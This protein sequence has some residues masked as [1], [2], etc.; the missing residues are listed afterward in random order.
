MTRPFVA[1]DRVRVVVPEDESEIVR[2]KGLPLE[3]DATVTEGMYEIPGHSPVTLPK[4][5][6]C[7]DHGWVMTS[8]LTHL[9]GPAIAAP[10]AP[11][12]ACRWCHGTG[13]VQLVF[14]SAPCECVSNSV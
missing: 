6:G 13:A 3:W 12:R 5:P 10:R 14:S 1:G 2:E 11:D 8:W 7:H 4:T 9:D